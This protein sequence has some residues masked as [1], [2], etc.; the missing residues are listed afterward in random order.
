MDKGIE[1]NST[2]EAGVTIL[3]GGW[4]DKGAESQATS[5]LEWETWANW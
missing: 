4:L 5:D 1:P 3:R 2:T